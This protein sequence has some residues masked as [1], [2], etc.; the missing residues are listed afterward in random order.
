MHT[1]AE[2]LA[3]AQ[4]WFPRTPAK[5]AFPKLTHGK[6]SDKANPRSLQLKRGEEHRGSQKHQAPGGKKLRECSKEKDTKTCDISEQ[7]LALPAEH[8]Y[9]TGFTAK[10]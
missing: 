10:S 6:A 4:V 5:N 7:Y 9:L 3:G 1:T 2:E 8:R